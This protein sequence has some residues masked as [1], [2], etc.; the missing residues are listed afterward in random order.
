M[1]KT[2]EAIIELYKK[3]YRIIGGECITP[4]GKVLTG[5]IK[6]HPV[7][8]KQVYIKMEGRSRSVFYHALLAYQL[9]GD[10]YFKEGIVAR[11][12]DGNSLNNKDDNIILGTMKDNTMDIPTKRRKKRIEQGIDTKKM[13]EENINAI[14]Q[15]YLNGMVAKELYKKY[16]TCLNTMYIII[17]KIKKGII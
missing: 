14:K 1:N 8:Y 6:W 2:Q 4:K 11:H 9:Y 12:K 5:S 7:P 13:L 15:D 16:N 17:R 3:G 10:E